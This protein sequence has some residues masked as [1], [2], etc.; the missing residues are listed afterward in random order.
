MKTETI[1]GT[2]RPSVAYV[3]DPL[4]RRDVT[5]SGAHK[6]NGI[7]THEDALSAGCV[8]LPRNPQLYADFMIDRNVTS[9]ASTAPGTSGNGNNVAV[10]AADG[11]TTVKRTRVKKETS[12]TS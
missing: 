8:S 6:N 5:S 2:E 9:R 12:S 10:A 1:S 7:K 3:E 4:T 11:F